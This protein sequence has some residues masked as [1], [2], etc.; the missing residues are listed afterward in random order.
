MDIGFVGLGQ[1]GGAM[2]GQLV[3]AGHA[4]KVWNRDPRK[5]EVL[6]AAGATQAGSAADAAKAEIVVSM[7][8]DDAALEAVAFG[9][10]GILSAGPGILHISSSTVSVALTDR[11]A[12]AHR[13]A[14]QAFVAAPVL[15]RPDVAA[16]GQLSILAAGSDAD[17]ARSQPVFDA[18]GQRVIRVGDE[19][20]MAVAAKLASNFSIAS[21]IETVTEAYAIAGARGVTPQAMYDLFTETGFGNRMFGNYGRMIADAAFE[22]AGFPLRLG[23][24][25]VGL[26]LAA[27]GDDAELPFARLLAERMDRII[28]ADGGRR[29][30]SALGQPPASA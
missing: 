9:A 2:A 5:A 21:V 19:P 27:A 11:L 3:A 22:P 23:R 14:G 12:A 10:D 1:M 29:D 30:W 18:V 4:V 8:A 28:A 15:G 13:E 16:A 26:G 20:G 17:L 7:L 6:I 24:K 25:D